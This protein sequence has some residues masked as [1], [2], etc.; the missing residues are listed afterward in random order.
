MS[1][2]PAPRVPP[3]VPPP[4]APATR[5]RTPRLFFPGCRNG[6]GMLRAC[7]LP[8]KPPG[9]R[10]RHPHTAPVPALCRRPWAL[11]PQPAVRRA[12]S[13]VPGYLRP[14][15]VCPCKKAGSVL[16]PFLPHRDTRPAKHGAVSLIRNVI[17]RPGSSQ[18]RTTLC[19]G[20][21][22]CSA[23]D[24]TSALSPSPNSRYLLDRLPAG[25]CRGQV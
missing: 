11:V 18:S 7:R 14:P 21:Y 8:V 22:T 25:L 19:K 16:A 3:P 6:P 23:R 17:P 13:F 24:T 4:Q 5:S 9:R 15:A 2:P 10:G 12:L 1:G 20:S